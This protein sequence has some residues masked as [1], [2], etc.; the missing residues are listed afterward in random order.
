MVVVFGVRKT[1]WRYLSVI[2][3]TRVSPQ[4]VLF[5]FSLFFVS[6]RR[7]LGPPTANGTEP[8]ETVHPFPFKRKLSF[9]RVQTF[10]SRNNNN[11]NN[12]GDRRRRRRVGDDEDRGQHWRGSTPPEPPPGRALSLSLSSFGT[13]SVFLLARLSRSR[14]SFSSLSPPT[15]CATRVLFVFKLHSQCERATGRAGTVLLQP[16]A[17]GLPG[18]HR[19]NKSDLRMLVGKWKHFSSSSRN[20]RS[21][22]H[23]AAAAYSTSR[24]RRVQMFRLIF[25]IVVSAQPVQ[26]KG[27]NQISGGGQ[28]L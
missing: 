12:S 11:N 23:P 8:R 14:R 16:T 5:K 25:R 17:R 2:S 26:L 20:P 13:G 24:H 1:A 21:T 7:S 15:S 27:I 10:H 9:L 22:P 19:Q 28:K 4:I 18:W 6:F 3:C